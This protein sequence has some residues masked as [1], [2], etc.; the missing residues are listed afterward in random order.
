MA[1]P[2][3]PQLAHRLGAALSAAGRHDLAGAYLTAVLAFRRRHLGHEIIGSDRALIRQACAAL[4]RAGRRR[5]ALHLA[6]GSWSV[7]GLLAALG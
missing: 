6:A 2:P 3:F 1:L 7:R 5:Q 4:A